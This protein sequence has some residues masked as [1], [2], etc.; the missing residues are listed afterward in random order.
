[1][2]DSCLRVEIRRFYRENGGI[3]GR[4][5]GVDLQRED[6]KSLTGPSKKHKIKETAITGRLF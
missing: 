2:P 3:F 6:E 1:M 5:A 4:G